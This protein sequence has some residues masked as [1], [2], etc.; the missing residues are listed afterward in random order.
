VG[1]RGVLSHPDPD[2][3]EILVEAFLIAMLNGRTAVLEYM[4]SRGFPVDS[5][6]YGS[7]LISMAVGNAMVPVV[8]CLAR[9]GANLDLRGWRPA[10]SARELARELFEDMS[11]DADRRRIVELCGMDA[12]AVL[13][14]R[15]ARPMNP[16][17]IHPKLEEA[18]ELAAD[19]AFRLGQSQV[20]PENLLFGLL[21][22]G[23]L[24]LTFF[25]QASRMDLDRF[26]ADVEGRV[27][28]IAERVEHPRLPLHPDAQA[29]IEAAI[30][31]ATE[32]RRQTVNG[33]FLL[34]ALTRAEHGAAADLL[35]RYGSSAATVNVELERVL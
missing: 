26:R 12:D 31:I 30:A 33:L 23:G 20:R 14:E 4:V 25:T 19:D 34:C 6:I 27:R 32:R 3:E 2:D 17:S 11:Q 28:P 15:D 35:A 8:E 10:Q 24:P 22:S 29:A 18:L 13:A 5:L 1:Q 21:R 16:P 9:C 7:P